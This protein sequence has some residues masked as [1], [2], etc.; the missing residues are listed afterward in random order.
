MKYKEL[1]TEIRA[2]HGKLTPEIVLEE[3][4][5]D[6]S[7]LHGYVFDKEVGD[8][9]EAYYLERA[10]QLIQR[11]RVVVRKNDTE[12]R[13]IRAFLAVPS[14]TDRYVYEPF[15]VVVSDEQKLNMVRLEAARRLRDA[16][17]AVEDLDL[18]AQGTPFARTSKRVKSAIRTARQELDKVA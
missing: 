1:L 16:E 17:T 6:D 8:A 9:A 11:V 18:L 12:Q 14:D 4:R 10:H 13:S 7:P 15:E 5:P 3:A 2:Q